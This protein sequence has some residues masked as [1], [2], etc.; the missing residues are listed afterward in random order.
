MLTQRPIDRARFPW[1][2][3]K[4]A[5]FFNMPVFR[6]TF[7]RFVQELRKQIDARC[8][9]SLLVADE[10]SSPVTS[11]MRFNTVQR[12]RE[13][14]GRVREEVCY[15]GRSGD[16][17]VPC[18]HLRS[19]QH[20]YRPKNMSRHG[21]AGW[22]R[23]SDRVAKASARLSARHCRRQTSI[24]VVGAAASPWRRPPSCGIRTRASRSDAIVW[25]TRTDRS[26]ANL[27]ARRGVDLP[28]VGRS[29]HYSGPKV[30]WIL[31][32]VR[33]RE[34]R[35]GISSWQHGYVVLWNLTRSVNWRRA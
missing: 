13:P 10:R 21:K 7:Q 17:V 9:R 24:A 18:D 2:K 4:A 15:G 34:A 8:D 25:R 32:N 35:A 28:I 22:V 26:F 11:F 3:L 5:T 14:N 31:D 16:D 6:V 1:L 29:V 27:L 19:R 23:R 30:K 33:V 12:R 20:V